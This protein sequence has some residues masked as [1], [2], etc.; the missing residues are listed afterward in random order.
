MSLYAVSDGFTCPAKVQ[1]AVDKAFKANR[2]T[3][4][5]HWLYNGS[6]WYGLLAID[7][8][9]LIKH[10]ISLHKKD[11]YIIDVGCAQGKWGRN[12][13]AIVS[14]YKNIRT[15]FHIF[16]IT[17]GQECQEA[18]LQINDN[19]VL[20]QLNQCK[21]ENIDEELLRRGFDLENKVDVIVSRWTMRHLVDPFGTLARMYTLLNP[22]G[23]KLFAN[24]FLF[25][26]AD[27]KK[28][29]A[30]PLINNAY[31]LAR[32]NAHVL[33]HLWTAGRDVC[34]FLLERNDDKPLGLP[35]RY[36]GNVVTLSMNY[37]C[38]SGKVT[39]FCGNKDVTHKVKVV[40]T[41]KGLWKCEH[42]WLEGDERSERL[43]A[44][45]KEQGLFDK[46]GTQKL[47]SKL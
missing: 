40:T 22:S 33:F 42:Y 19:I 23:G 21:I 9:V 37:Q 15:K 12:I 4:D 44:S 32:S 29:E 47:Q 17:G 1:A 36:T 8:E 43:Y 26:Y 46:P 13:A 31:I 34:E 28:I 45:L 11:I 5:D 38:S 6:Q 7:E 16:S 30:C 2:D 39:E 18:A 25:K 20:Y 24:G 10:L 35:L 14:G 3:G 41:Q 27:S